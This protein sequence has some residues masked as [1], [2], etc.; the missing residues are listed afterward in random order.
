MSIVA[1]RGLFAAET[2]AV[3]DLGADDVLD[4]YLVHRL[5][6]CFIEQFNDVF[7]RFEGKLFVTGKFSKVLLVLVRL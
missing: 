7:G 2:K 5:L 3:V 6:L 1:P 4:A